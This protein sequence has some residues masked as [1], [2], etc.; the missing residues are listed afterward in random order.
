MDL[1]LLAVPFFFV[2]I[3]VELVADRVRGQRNY[4]L[5]DSINSLSTGALSTSTGLLTKG[6]GL[7]AYALA[8]E[9][10][11][12]LRLPAQ[13]WWVWLLAFFLY[14]FCYYWLHRLGHER[15]VL[16]AAHSVHHQSEEY[17]LTTALRQ[18][19]SGFIFSW[20]FYL[21]LALV[22]VPPAVFIT[23]ASLNLLYQFWVHTRHIAKL[24]WLEWVLITPSNHR[25]HHAQNPAYLDRNYGGVFIFW[26]R[27][28]GTFKEED[29]AEPVVF[30]V[31]TPLA[32]WN[33]L[34]ANLQFYAQLWQ[35]ARRAGSLWDKLRIWFMPT[36]WRPADVAARYPHGKQDL[37]LFR[38]FEVALGRPQQAYV[39]AQFVVYLAL[40][41][42]LMGVAER[43]PTAALV[44]GWS[45]MAFGLFVLGA[46]LENRPWATRLEQVRLV[47]SA[48]ALYLAGASGLAVVVPLAWFLLVA[49]G[50]LSLWGLGLVRRLALRTQGT[51]APAQP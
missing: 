8:F 7:L 21:P 13:A 26:D 41:S 6:L 47:A 10:L 4:T 48:P 44:L 50:L 35:D 37:A 15:N 51:E 29:P 14:D 22:G 27:L 36:G 28:F 31:T 9:H 43:V 45:L 2:L 32:S 49:Y 30:G 34:W 25:V 5:A 19:S 46:L 16:W 12:L 24:G 18:T 23:V 1:I 11:A 42:Y 39:A 20:I 17:N 33:P 40:G 38:K 3:A